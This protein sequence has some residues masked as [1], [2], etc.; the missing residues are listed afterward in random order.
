M[1]TIIDTELLKK[2]LKEAISETLH[3]ERGFLHE[4]IAEVMEEIALSE[5]I[6]EGQNTQPVEREIIFKLLEGER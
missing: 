4:I 2:T 3:E 5:A 6:R 1:Q